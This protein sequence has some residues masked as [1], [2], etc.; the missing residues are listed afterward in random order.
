MARCVTS[1]AVNSNLGDAKLFFG[2]I[3]PEEVAICI[4]HINKE[5][6]ENLNKIIS[7]LIVY[8][9]DNTDFYSHWDN[10]KSRINENDCESVNIIFS[11][12][13][14]I[15]HEII[16]SKVT[17]EVSNHNLKSLGF[18]EHI[19]HLI[20][21]A[22]ID[23]REKL[24]K[25]F[26]I[27]PMGFPKIKKLRWRVDVVMSSGTLSKVMQQT[28]TMQIST[29]DGMVRTFEVSQEKFAEMRQGVAKAMNSLQ[30]L[31]RHPIMR[32]VKEFDR[33]DREELHFCRNFSDFVR[34]NIATDS[35]DAIS[36]H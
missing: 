12:L 7:I 16:R 23:I 1:D 4:D 21:A 5:P 8:I 15:I 20:N 9:L 3:V 34:Y 24:E 13:Y 28:V 32:I 22:L 14:T 17:L 27:E 31:E 18:A 2:S 33:K 29:T 36:T 6:E 25:K 26:T 35:V 11:G 19:S 30:R 10:F